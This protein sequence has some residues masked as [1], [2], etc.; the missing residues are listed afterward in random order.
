LISDLKANARPASNNNPEQV[1][2]HGKE[3]G[4]NCF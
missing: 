3:K 2:W 1:G 4:H